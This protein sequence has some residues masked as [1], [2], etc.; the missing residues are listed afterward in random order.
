MN[1]K[2]RHKFINYFPNIITENIIKLNKI[3][4]SPV[5]TETPIVSNIIPDIGKEYIFTFIKIHNLNSK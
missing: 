3:Y 5:Q 1:P 4:N 2:N